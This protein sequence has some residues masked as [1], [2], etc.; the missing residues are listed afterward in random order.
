MAFESFV[1]LLDGFEGLEELHLQG[2]GEPMMH[3]RFFDM[4]E[5]AA[6]RG[7]RVTTNSNFTLVTRTR[8]ER[9]AR[10]RLH[11]IHVSVDG[12]RP[13]S[14]EA[15]RVRGRFARV[16]HNLG[17][18][19]DARA[20]LGAPGPRLHIVVVV[21][22][23]NLGELAD[24]VRL[25]RRFDAAQ[26]FVQHL[27]HDFGEASLPSDYAPMRQY[28]EEQ[29]LLNESAERID[30]AFDEASRVAA[31]LGMD[32]RLPR[33]RVKDH[34]P[35]TPGRERCNWPW[36]GA[37]VSYQGLA[38]PCCMISTPDRLNFGNMVEAGVAATWHGTSCEAFRRALDSD[39]PPDI[40]KSCAVYNGT[41]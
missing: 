12:A 24:I 35:G 26:V 29:T 25:A 30:A 28:V 5:E 40:C 23:Q 39:T 7:I 16:V 9:L 21:M 41:F 27:C 4:V 13:E 20:R 32:L 6:G 18:F 3:P 11:C 8:A 2:L 15:I 10:S 36:K 17:L 22:R 38:M 34:P 1:K 33:T 31:E 37:Y 19:A 14:Y